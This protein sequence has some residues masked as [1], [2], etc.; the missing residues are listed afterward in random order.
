MKGSYV[1]GFLFVV[2]K[3]KAVE[4]KKMAEW[5]KK[6]WMKHGALDYKECMGD[7]ITPK[8]SMPGIKQLHFPRV[9]KAKKGETVWFSFIVFKSRKHR[10][11]VNAKVMKDPSMNDDTWK[12]KPMPMDMKRFAYGGFKVEVGV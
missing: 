1:D 3:G 4:Y 7:D 2:P 11:E 12:D 5:G 8:G 10:D 6:L 9:I